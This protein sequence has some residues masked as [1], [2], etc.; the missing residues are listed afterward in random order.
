[1][2]TAAAVALAIGISAPV[3]AILTSVIQGRFTAAAKREDARQA[4]NATEA[5]SSDSRDARAFGTLER[6]LARLATRV[7]TLE[8]RIRDLEKDLDASQTRITDLQGQVYRL[9]T[10]RDALKRE[11]GQLALLAK[12]RDDQILQLEKRLNEQKREREELAR[13]LA[14]YRQGVRQTDGEQ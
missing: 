13:Q 6:E 12:E 10:E 7:D 2:D 1:M 8:T 4:T 3:S 9:E 14:C 11:N 5:Q